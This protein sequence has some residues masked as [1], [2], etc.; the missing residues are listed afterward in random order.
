MCTLSH[1]TVLFS[2]GENIN[3][4]QWC[5]I[6]CLIGYIARKVI[7]HRK[8]WKRQRAFGDKG[9]ALFPPST[10]Q[11]NIVIFTLNHSSERLQ[12]AFLE[13]LKCAVLV[14]LEIWKGKWCVFKFSR[15]TILHTS[16]FLFLLLS[17]GIWERRKV[18]GGVDG[19]SSFEA[20][21]LDSP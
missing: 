19:E 2:Y 5:N 3:A 12:K 13:V 11:D 21:P 1:I 7:S 6:C 17:G 20:T 18:E 15:L 14:W 16:F 8:N 10:V 9:E 4:D